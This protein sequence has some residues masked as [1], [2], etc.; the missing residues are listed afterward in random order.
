VTVGIGSYDLANDTFTRPFLNKNQFSTHDTTKMI[1]IS[2]NLFHAHKMA[3]PRLQ[4][5]HTHTHTHTYTHTHTHTHTHTEYSRIRLL[6]NDTI[7]QNQA[8]KGLYI[9]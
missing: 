3:T 5:T 4:N 2:L 9:H 8:R 6:P 7:G 1:G